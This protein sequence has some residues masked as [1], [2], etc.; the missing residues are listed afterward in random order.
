MNKPVEDQAREANDP[1]KWDALWASEGQ[2]TWRQGALGAVYDRV[3][4]LVPEGA[5][6]LDVG[7]GVGVLSRR[8]RDERGAVPTVLDHSQEAV[9]QALGVGLDARM[10]DLE[11][12]GLLDADG[13]LLVATEV[14]EHLSEAARER[15]VRAAALAPSALISVPHDRLGPDEEPQHTIRWTALEFLV[16][17]RVF[18]GARCRVEILPGGYM[19]GVCGQLAEKPYRLSVTLPV[20]D[21]A[22]DLE[23]VLASFRGA[24]DEIVVGVDPRTTD[25]TREVAARYAEVVFELAS[26]RGPVGDEVAAEG[27]VHFAW[28]RNQCIERCSGDWVFMTEGHESLAEGTDHLLRLHELVPERAVAA[29]VAR[30]GQGQQWA[31]PWLCRPHMRYGRATHNELQIP[32]GAYV[33]GLPQ[34]RT[35]HFRDHARAVAR[36]EQR[37]A[38]NK[39]WLMADW[40]ERQSVQSLFY[41]SQEWRG[42]DPRRARERIEQFIAASNNGP[43]RYQARLI[44]AKELGLTGDVDG[45]RAVLCGCTADDWSRTEHYVW[46][47]DLAVDAG[48][49]EE[50]YQW[51]RLSATRIG[52]PPFTT[53]WI[54]LSHYSYLPCQRLA[55]VAAALDRADEATVWAQRA[56]ELLPGDAPLEVVA[57]A[58]DNLSILLEA[59]E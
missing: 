11:A 4:R 25:A 42:V 58:K 19:L 52:S 20:R 36:A 21:E 22:A 49:L 12:P 38:Q 45:A 13:A 51:Y 44:L 47:G 29:L 16:Y 31:F 7:G 33:V 28:L 5:R 50:A 23:R 35:D 32:K 54:D 3:V 57:E 46:L 59:A 56:V 53:W 6:V 55:M 26:P 14:V 27:G 9:L 43:H 17:L 30:S 40:L 24:A 10:L 34:V 8:L 1:R 2:E 41:L 39:L 48:K 18:F 15:L 37:G